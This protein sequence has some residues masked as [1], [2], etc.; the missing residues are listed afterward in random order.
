MIERRK[1]LKIGASAAVASMAMPFVGRTGWAATPTHTLK[2]TFADTQAHPLYDVLKRFAEDVNKRTSGAI[3]IQVFS[4]GQLGSGTNILTGM[5]TGIIDFCAH[6]SGFVDTIYPKFQ[7]V[8]LPF[9]FSDAASAE[10]LLDGPT[11]AKMLD[12]LPAKG[13][14][15]LGYG[16]WGWRVVSTIDRKAPEPD[17]MKGLKIRVQPGAIFAS[18]FKALGASPVAIDLTEVYLALSQR[19]IDAVETPMISLAATKHDE[20]VG[21][22]A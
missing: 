14:Y 4:I 7:V 21:T 20:I 10:K 2:L 15:G 13:I 3:E 18:T 6:T 19:V 16:H 9:L 1:I 17:G 22:V 5:Q 12:M 11:G 8:D